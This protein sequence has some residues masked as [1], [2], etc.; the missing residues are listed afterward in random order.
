M[1]ES[2]YNEGEYLGQSREAKP[3]I[4]FNIIRVPSAAVDER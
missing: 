3:P 2:P 4:S 1:W